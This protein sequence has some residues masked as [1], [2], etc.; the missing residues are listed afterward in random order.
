MKVVLG[1]RFI[2]SDKHSDRGTRNVVVGPILGP[3][4][5]VGVTPGSG[6]GI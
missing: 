4:D 3:Q 5:A 1:G 2:K 6:N